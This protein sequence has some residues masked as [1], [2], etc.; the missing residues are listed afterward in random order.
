[1]RKEFHEGD[2]NGN[3]V[4]RRPRCVRVVASRQK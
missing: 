3:A 2:L 1:L 4:K